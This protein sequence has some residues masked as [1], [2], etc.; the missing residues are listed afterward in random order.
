M[1]AAID[2][3]ASTSASLFRVAAERLW[4]TE[5]NNDSILNMATAQF[6][7]LD[8]IGQG[9]DHA[10]LTHRTEASNMG[11]RLGLFGVHDNVARSSLASL[12]AEDRSAYAYTA[13]GVFNWIM[14]VPWP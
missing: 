12:T 10:V 6:L 11:I 3:R 13:W 4:Y 2:H 14:Q 9:K 5:R 7:S 1:Y 8:F